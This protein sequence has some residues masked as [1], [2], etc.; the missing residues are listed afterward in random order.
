M[1]FT[2]IDFLNAALDDLVLQVALVLLIKQL[3]HLG[4]L[5]LILIKGL[6]QLLLDKEVLLLDLLLALLQL[7]PLPHLIEQEVSVAHGAL[8]SVLG[9]SS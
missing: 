7:L 3:A 8:L 6:L 5:G 1:H 4:P 2:L 9:L